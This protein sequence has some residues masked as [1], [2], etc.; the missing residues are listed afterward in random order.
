LL[1]ASS[2]I[3]NKFLTVKCQDD[4][5]VYF[6]LKMRN[7]VIGVPVGAEEMFDLLSEVLLAIGKNAPHVDS[8]TVV[9]MIK[10]AG[11]MYHM[12]TG[13]TES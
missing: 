10:R 3:A 13:R 1:L 12:A 11:V 4:G 7:R 5:S 2:A 6:Q 9:Q 8:Q